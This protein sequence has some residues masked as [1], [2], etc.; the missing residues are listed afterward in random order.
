MRL[1]GA[2][3]LRHLVVAYAISSAVAGVAGALSAQTNAFVGLEVL[4]LNTSI[5]GLVMLVLGGIGRLYGGL[6]GA[7]VYMFVQHFAQQWNPYY[8]MFLIGGLLILIVRF[9]R[10]GLLGLV[11]D[12]ARRFG[13]R[14]TP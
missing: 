1:L 7:P 13:R 14:R 4:S 6:I 9:S 2:P 11:D 8:W 3:V 12:L 10:G 5:D